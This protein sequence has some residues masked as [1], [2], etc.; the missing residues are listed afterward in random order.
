[1]D[2]KADPPGKAHFARGASGRARGLADDTAVL[3]VGG[4]TLC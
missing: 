3:A 4:G 2:A 1:M